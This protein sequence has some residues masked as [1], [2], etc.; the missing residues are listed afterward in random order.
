MSSFP[1][2]SYMRL[3]WLLYNIPYG[4]LTFSAANLAQGAKHSNATALPHRTVQHPS[5]KCM[6]E[7]QELHMRVIDA[8]P[9][10]KLSLERC[11]KNEIG[12]ILS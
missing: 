4:I 1:G 2:G 7:R 10:I 6:V 8:C 5:A 11:C 9:K 12:V 3:Q